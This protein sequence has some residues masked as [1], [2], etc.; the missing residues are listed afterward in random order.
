MNDTQDTQ[1]TQDKGKPLHVGLHIQKCAGTTLQTHIAEC[2][3]AGSWFWH[4]SADVNYRNSSLE[5]DARNTPSRQTVQVIWGHEVFDYFLRFFSDRPIHLF[6]FIR[7]PAKRIISWYKYEARG[8]EK[9]RGTLEG[10]PNF[11]QFMSDKR[12]HMCRFIIDRFSSL[13]TSGSEILHK[14]A[15]SILDK[16]AFIGVQED[17]QSGANH[18]LKFMGLPS[19]PED[20]RK[21]VDDGNLDL[22]YNMETIIGKNKQDMALYEYVLERYLQSSV[23]DPSRAVNPLDYGL[24]PNSDSLR[25]FIQLRGKS[26]VNRLSE[27]KLT[28]LY[29]K[30]NVRQIAQ[31]LIRQTLAENNPELQEFY[32]KNLHKLVKEF[33]LNLSEEE[34]QNIPYAKP[35]L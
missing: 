5:I 4:T 11:E 17:F 35:V 7:H 18:L 30:D 6:T 22:E 24:S 31:L 1:D 14:R 10:F 32:L 27:Q 3:R 15:V 28:N 19:L 33:D 29:K 13:D 2:P 34:I 8:Y 20:S 12:N 16:F 26:I 21:N 23:P 25:S 9:A